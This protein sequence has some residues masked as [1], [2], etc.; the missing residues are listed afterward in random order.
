MGAVVAALGPRT[1]SRRPWIL[2]HTPPRTAWTRASAPWR[3]RCQNFGGFEEEPLVNQAPLEAL[4]LVTTPTG[5]SSQPLRLSLPLDGVLATSVSL[6]TTHPR[7]PPFHLEST[8]QSRTSCRHPPQSCRSPRCRAQ[9]PTGARGVGQ[10]TWPRSEPVC[11]P[12]SV[13]SSPHTW[14]RL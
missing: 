6:L 10:A 9:G 2:S 3:A 1:G 11:T 8:G 7:Q 5:L 4:M 12:S 13:A 14:W